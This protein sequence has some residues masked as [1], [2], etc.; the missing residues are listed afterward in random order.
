MGDVN[1]REIAERLRV[2]VIEA[3]ALQLPR[4]DLESVSELISVG[5]YGIA[6]EDLCT[7]L[8]EHEIPVTG[9]LRHL[10][11]EVGAA[12]Q[13]DPS[14]WTDLEELDPTRSH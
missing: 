8:Y 11:A 6:L 12:M 3:E 5:E 10:L 13:M 9:H 2:C 7:Q 1:F 14:N 4:C